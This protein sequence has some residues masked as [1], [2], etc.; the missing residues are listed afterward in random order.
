MLH[1]TIQWILLV[2][3]EVDCQIPRY[4]MNLPSPGVV[5]MLLKTNRIPPF[6][7]ENVAFGGMQAGVSK[8]SVVLIKT[9]QR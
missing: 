1:E 7:G 4:E 5:K 2:F 3:V 8:G 9:R 6:S